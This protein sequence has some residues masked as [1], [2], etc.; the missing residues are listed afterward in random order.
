M[1]YATEQTQK[2]VARLFV[3]PI[4]V[5]TEEDCLIGALCAGSLT[6]GC[7]ESSPKVSF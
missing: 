3:Y 1:H 4:S 2:P 5:V 6:D 7:L